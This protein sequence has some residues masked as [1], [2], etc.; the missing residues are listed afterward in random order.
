MQPLRLF[1]LAPALMLTL[2]LAACSNHPATSGPASS[3]SGD[4]SAM[5]N[6]DNTPAESQHLAMGCLSPNATWAVG[7]PLDDA[8]IAKA[9][10]DAQA[11]Y[12]R[13]IKP[14]MAVTM[15]YNGARLNLHV[16][17]RNIV[18]AAICG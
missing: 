14:G 3:T 8:L 16:N 9:K 5:N 13:V 12:V 17:A 6:K 15:E 11:E 18:T 4:T 1:S 2:A 7:K 10:A